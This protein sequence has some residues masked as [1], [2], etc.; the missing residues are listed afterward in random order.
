MFTVCFVMLKNLNVANQTPGNA[1][2]HTMSS[3]PI[4]LARYKEMGS[5]Q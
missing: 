5:A 3:F 4:F 2:M 1:S